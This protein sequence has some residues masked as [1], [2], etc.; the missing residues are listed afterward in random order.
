MTGDEA[1]EFIKTDEFKH[2]EKNIIASYNETQNMLQQLRETYKLDQDYFWMI[3]DVDSPRV[4][5]SYFPRE[6][7]YGVF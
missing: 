4:F 1:Y 3:I 6:M 5:P 7:E 2:I